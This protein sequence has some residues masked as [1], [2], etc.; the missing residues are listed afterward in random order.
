MEEE[1]VLVCLFACLVWLGY[2][3]LVV[4]WARLFGGTV[5]NVY[6]VTHSVSESIGERVR[7]AGRRRGSVAGARRHLAPFRSDGDAVSAALVRVRRQRLAVALFA[8]R[9]LAHVQ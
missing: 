4:G 2:V 3:R 5:E 7:M 6:K 8:R 1:H 9:T